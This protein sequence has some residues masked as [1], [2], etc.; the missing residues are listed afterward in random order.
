MVDD[1]V[2][3][4]GPFIF[5][6]ETDLL[7]NY[8]FYIIATAQGGAF[9]KSDM[10]TMRVKFQCYL[11]QVTM[12]YDMPKEN[13]QDF[14]MV[15]NIARLQLEFDVSDENGLEYKYDLS[16]RFVQKA[17]LWEC[18]MSNYKIYNTPFPN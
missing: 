18:P 13:K 5:P 11:D 16:E 17:P 8:T 3:D 1:N 10:Y 14:I 2:K 4:T 6:K 7:H 12:K 15:K 9:L